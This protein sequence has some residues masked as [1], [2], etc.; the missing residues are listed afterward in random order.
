[1]FGH[2]VGVDRRG[3][4]HRGA[5]C[6]GAGFRGYERSGAGH[7]GNAYEGAGYL[8]AYGEQPIRQ[9]HGREE[10]HE[11]RMKIDLLSFNGHPQIEYFVD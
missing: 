9:D 3:E 7:M 6:G 8:D 2:N 5:D 4:G 1:V 10:P 11:Y